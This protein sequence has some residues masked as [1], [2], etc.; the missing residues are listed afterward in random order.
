M[1]EC[2]TFACAWGRLAVF[3]FQVVYVTVAR[4]NRPL[5]QLLLQRRRLLQTLFLN[6]SM[7]TRRAPPHATATAAAAAA[8]TATTIKA[9]S[10]TNATN[11]NA[12]GSLPLPPPPLARAP[13]NPR[14]SAEFEVAQLKRDAAAERQSRTSN[15]GPG[16]AAAAAARSSTKAHAEA[17]LAQRAGQRSGDPTTRDRRV[18][19]GTD[20]P[21][22]TGA[23][24]DQASLLS[25]A[26]VRAHLQKQ[27]KR[28]N[29]NSKI[30]R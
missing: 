12:A 22:L 4:P 5:L 18:A 8:T 6:G 21:W 11:A 24:V 19:V 20:A 7:L 29:T 10:G 25:P 2:L 17:A 30:Q 1:C 9:A 3:Y 28:V 15:P 23:H 27:T 14:K 13:R 26:E 16:S